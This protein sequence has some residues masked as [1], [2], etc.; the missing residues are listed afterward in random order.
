MDVRNATARTPTSQP[1]Q[2]PRVVGVRVWR[3]ILFVACLGGLALGAAWSFWPSSP[4]LPVLARWKLPGNNGWPLA[5]TPDGTRL[6]TAH[7]QQG[8][9]IWDLKTRTVVAKSP[10]TSWAFVSPISP[11]GQSLVV[12]RNNA[13]S[14]GIRMEVID[15]SDGSVKAT[16]NAPQAHL[17]DMRFSKDGSRFLT[18]TSAPPVTTLPNSKTIPWEFRS[19]GTSDW[20]EEPVQTRIL[21]PTASAAVTSDGRTLAARDGTKHGI[22][23]WDLSTEPPSSNLI[24]DPAPSTAEVFS[25]IRFSPDDRTLGVGRTDGTLELWDV[26]AK[27][28]KAAF[29]ATATSYAPFIIQFSPDE[30]TLFTQDSEWVANRT[31]LW[32][33][34]YIF[35]WAATAGRY[36]GPPPFV[37][38]RDIASGKIR[39]MLKD[40]FRPILSSDGKVLATASPDGTLTLWDLSSPG[41]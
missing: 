24:N 15:T 3:R 26:V 21:P 16:L 38:V 11:D 19:W 28:R 17:L 33:L 8:L 10:S 31:L 7:P 23:V 14:N 29:P 37:V 40:Q 9:S 5:F 35:N 4:G 39:A 25:M 41:K 18:I 22:A 20:L 6:I 30:K 32:R 34:N 36:E 12:R 1:R 2:R 13:I 27:K